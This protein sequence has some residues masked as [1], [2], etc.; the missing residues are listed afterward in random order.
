ML[1]DIPRSRPDQKRAPGTWVHILQHTPEP[2]YRFYWSAMVWCPECGKPLSC[3][4][5]TIADDGQITPS[6]GH[7]IEFPSCSWH[8]SPK[9]IG[10]APKE[11]GTPETPSPETCARCGKVSHTIGGWGTWSQGGIICASCFKTVMCSTP[12]GEVK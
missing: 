1:V 5:H 11:W 9:L 8:V 7:P 2:E 12:S 4:N 3:I 6:L 10:W